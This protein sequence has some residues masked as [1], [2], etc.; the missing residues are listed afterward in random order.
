M[1]EGVYAGIDDGWFQGEIADAAFD[2]EKRV[3]AGTRVIVGVNAF[4]SGDEGP[5]EILR[6]TA[7]HEAV[8]RSRLAEVRGIRDDHAVRAALKSVRAVAAD[9]DANLMPALIDA[10]RVFASV[11]EIMDALAQE[12]GRYVETPVL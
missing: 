5:P 1:L 8:Q 11:G 4:T 6:I 7:E 2:F 3:A 12:F 10:V 9:N